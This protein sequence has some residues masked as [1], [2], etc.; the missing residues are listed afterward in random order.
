MMFLNN[1]VLLLPLLFSDEKIAEN[2]ASVDGRD[3][4]T[5]SLIAGRMARRQQLIRDALAEIQGP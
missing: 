3:D 2:Y 5:A 4:H 1:V